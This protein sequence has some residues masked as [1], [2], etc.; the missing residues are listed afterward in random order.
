MTQLHGPHV[1]LAAK[2][3]P[4]CQRFPEKH[5]ICLLDVTA[6]MEYLPGQVIVA[7]G[8]SGMAVHVVTEGTA[9]VVLVNNHGEVNGCHGYVATG[10]PVRAVG[11]AGRQTLHRSAGSDDLR[12]DACD[13]E[14]GLAEGVGPAS[15]NRQEFA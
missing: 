2:H 10:R 7:S 5:L 8:D 15:R 13:K 11:S 4:V 12:Q 3:L 6:E 9:R 1:S 14:A